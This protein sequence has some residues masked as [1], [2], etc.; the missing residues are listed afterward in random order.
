MTTNVSPPPNKKFKSYTTQFYDDADLD[1]A[2]Y[3]ITEAKRARHKLEMYLQM[4]IAKYTES[5]NGTDN[6]LFFWKEQKDILP[7]SVE[8]GKQ[9]FCIL[10]AHQGLQRREENYFQGKED[11]E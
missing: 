11:C 9:I 3:H 1:D 4:S 7:I 6:P 2:S 8:T 10:A 5:N